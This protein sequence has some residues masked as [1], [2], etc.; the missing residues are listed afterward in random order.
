MMRPERAGACVTGL[1]W[2]AMTAAA[3]S[4]LSS[5]SA[6]I[7]DASVGETYAA[8]WAV[9]FACFEACVAVM[10]GRGR[11]T[12]IKISVGVTALACI[13]VSILVAMWG[14]RMA[15]LHVPLAIC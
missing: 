9:L 14:A 10:L 1:A 5:P 11:R 13:A 15:A 6:W 8:A 2:L 4:F 7:T 3:L 12:G